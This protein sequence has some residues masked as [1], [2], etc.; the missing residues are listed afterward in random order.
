[1]SRKIRFMVT[2]CFV[3]TSLAAV[4]V[5]CGDV[6]DAENN[7]T[8]NGTNNGVASYRFV[9]LEDISDDVATGDT[10]GADIDAIAIER[11][12]VDIAFAA[13]V[14]DENIGGANN[15]YT[16]SNELLGEPDSECMKQ[17]FTALGGAPNDGYV[18][19]GFGDATIEIGDN[20]V[21]Y[22][23]GPTVCESQPTWKD[24]ETA[25]SVNVSVQ[26]PG[27]ASWILLG[28]TGTGLNLIPVE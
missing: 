3:V 2:L 11:G 28:S 26:D 1:M 10:P 9:L 22:E 25:V 12:G 20:I 5:A 23:L 13:T 16:D 4:N 17:N 19:V 6:E 14:E 15:A 21:V 27:D 7:G 8:N 18:I 24:D